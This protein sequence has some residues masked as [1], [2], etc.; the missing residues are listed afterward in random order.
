MESGAPF[1]PRKL[2]RHSGGEGAGEGGEEGERKFVS[3]RREDESAGVLF[4]DS[5]V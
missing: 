1:R 5:S 2:D 4:G 3:K